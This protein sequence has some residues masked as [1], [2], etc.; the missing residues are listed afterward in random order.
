MKLHHLGFM[1]FACAFLAAGAFVTPEHRPLTSPPGSAV[2]FVID[3]YQDNVL[4]RRCECWRYRQSS[5]GIEPYAEGD[6]DPS[7]E[8]IR[9]EW[10]QAV[11][12]YGIKQEGK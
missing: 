8:P 9:Y 12:I 1:F 4:V 11:E 7:L 3:V 6:A 10:G 2:N 5:W